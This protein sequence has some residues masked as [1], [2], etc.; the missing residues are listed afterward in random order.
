MTVHLYA[1]KPHYAEHLWPIWNAIPAELRG[2]SWSPRSSCWW[3][4]PLPHPRVRPP[5]HVMVAA[6]ADA[7]KMA[8]RRLV[9]VEH[10][11]GQTYDGDTAG[12]GNGSY[13][14]GD[15]LDAADLFIAPGEHVARRWRQRYDRP[16]SVAGCPKLDDWHACRRGHRATGARPLVAVTFHW[17]CSL[18][19]E[20]LSARRH[21]EDALTSLRDAVR[22]CGGELL[23]HGHPRA[24]GS[25]RAL[26]ASL[27]VPHT[28]HL[29]DVL[30]QADLL[31]GDNTSALYEFASLDRPVV[32]LNAPWYRRDVDH[33]LRF[34]SHVPGVEV[35]EPDLLA[36]TVIN[37]LTGDTPTTTSLRR[38][39][40]DHVYAHRDGRAAE[41]AAAA[42]AEVL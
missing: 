30:D 17:E 28:P 35:D 22:A 26:W 41:R 2:E 8:P 24:W 25:L 39:A 13:S 4:S 34:W 1:S 33:G 29:A 15:G 11:A 32:V 14:G 20:T 42:I 3:G 40:V 23:G 36:D 5:G 19:P 37:A 7:R 31:A 18:V 12:R 27:G 16:V 10:G 9:Y 6:F 38:R 21:Y